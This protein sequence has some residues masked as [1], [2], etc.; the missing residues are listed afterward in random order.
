VGRR[1][2][3]PVGGDE[4]AQRVPGCLNVYVQ[5]LREAGKQVE[6]YEPDHGPHG[7]YYGRRG[8][9]PEYHEVT[10]RDVAFFQDRFQQAR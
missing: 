2:V 9:T 3:P 7:V 1:I 6:A 4:Q 5:K 8:D 10:R